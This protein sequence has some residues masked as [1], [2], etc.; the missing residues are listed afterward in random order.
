MEERVKKIIV[1]IDVHPNY[2]PDGY[3][4]RIVLGNDARCPTSPTACLG[5]R[6][7]S[8]GVGGRFPLINDVVVMVG[9]S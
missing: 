7:I 2:V 4:N 6:Q 9:L 3:C 5:S 1:T 8:E